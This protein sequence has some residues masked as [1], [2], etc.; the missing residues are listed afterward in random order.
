MTRIR[1]SQLLGLAVFLVGAITMFIGAT[2]DAQEVSGEV[3]I[4][5]EGSTVSSFS[6]S[7]NTWGSNIGGT[8]EPQSI[9]VMKQLGRFCPDAK[10]TSD[11]EKANYLLLHER[12]ASGSSGGNR[13]NIALFGKNDELLYADGARQLDN[14]V[15]DL[16]NSEVIPS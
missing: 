2:T 15:K 4:F 3:I 14:A 10:I 9:E 6:G 12:Q 11:R 8:S 16:C 13:N 5:V 1:T 7:G